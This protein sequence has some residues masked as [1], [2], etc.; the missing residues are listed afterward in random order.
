MVHDIELLFD[1]LGWS[2]ATIV[3]QSMGGINAFLFDAAQPGRVDR[4]V[5]VDIGP[6]VD[7][8]GAARI[9]ANVG[10]P[11]VFA[12][13]DEALAEGRRLFPL[14]DAG[15]LVDRIRHNVI[16][17]ESGAL[18]WRTDRRLRDGSAQRDDHTADE[19]WSAWRHGR[20]PLLLVHG[21]HSDILTP[22]LIE[23]L[24]E[25]RPNVTVVDIEGAGHAVPLDRPEALA[26][27][28]TSFLAPAAPSA[29]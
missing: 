16:E 1:W 14:A 26:A 24:L 6:E 21:T 18:T 9:Q 12:S 22:P 23:R 29:P 13:F 8:A 5:I 10:N 4:L 28:V 2:T 20:A 17:T 15:L 19:R 25:A 3:G 11:D 7:P 27:A